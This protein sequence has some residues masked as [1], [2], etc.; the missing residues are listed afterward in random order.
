M[1]NTNEWFGETSDASKYDKKKQVQE[2]LRLLHLIKVK[3]PRK[4][5]S[6]HSGETDPQEDGTSADTHSERRF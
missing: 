3:K 5:C 6:K 1:R 2:L 4:K